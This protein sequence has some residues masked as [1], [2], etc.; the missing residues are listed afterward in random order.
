MLQ[1][2]DN[3]TRA[4]AGRRLSLAVVLALLLAAANGRAA[5]LDARQ[6]AATPYRVRAMVA[7]DD[8]QRPQP[9]LAASVV[10][11]LGERSEATLAPLWNLELVTADDPAT[12]R[13]CLQPAG[14]PSDWT[15]GEPPDALRSNDKLIWLGVATTPSGYELHAREFDVYLRRW[16][17][18][19]QKTVQQSAFVQEAAFQL[20]QDVFSPL[21]LVDAKPEDE[22]HVQLTFK[23]SDLPRRPGAAP[24]TTPG[25]LLQPLLRR[26]DRSGKLVE[27]GIQPVPWTLLT[28]AGETDGVWQADI[29]SGSRRPF[30]VRRG[31]LTQQL[32]IGLRN[33]PGPA[34]VRF[35]ARIDK[36]LGLAGYEVFRANPDGSSELLGVT[37]RDGAIVVPPSAGPLTMI[38]LR[39]DGQLLAKL[40]VASGA[41]ET[42]ETPIADD[43]LRLRAQAEARVVREELIDV[44]ARRAILMARVRAMLKGDR[45]E[46]AAKLMAELDALPTSAAFGRTI[47]NAAQRIP[48]SRDARVQDAIEKLFT[49]T[50][51]MLAQFLS[52]SAITEL[53][54]EVNAAARGGS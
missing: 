36:A 26:T 2:R 33:Q 44:V 35:H 24:L 32:A 14:I 9:G 22:Q 3:A 4:G 46:E 23:G 12:R 21:A 7:V 25:A 5:E 39:S 20:L 41:D 54:S 51:E 47:D 19:R 8:G 16:S 28:V 40:P 38:L 37:D 42:L 11:R 50:R 49:T 15:D 43:A 52:P 29:H 1:V 53:Q 30:A 13:F 48:T 6:W 18:P 34:R 45:Q 17:P 10:R 31:G 27:N